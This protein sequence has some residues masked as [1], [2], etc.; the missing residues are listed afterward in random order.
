MKID[1]QLTYDRAA[2]TIGANDFGCMR[3]GD[4][5]NELDRQLDRLSYLAA[6]SAND[7]LD[8]RG[9]RLDAWDVIHAKSKLGNGSAGLDGIPPHVWKAVLEKI[10]SV[11]QEATE[12][13]VTKAVQSI[14]TFTS[15]YCSALAKHLFYIKQARVKEL[16]DEK[17]LISWQLSSLMSNTAEVDRALIVLLEFANEPSKFFVLLD[18]I[19]YC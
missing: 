3:F 4:S 14:K 2:W 8:G 10:L 18:L 5:N 7:R 1:G 9:V 6:A 17:G 16:R 13:S 11:T 12:E 19:R 15:Q